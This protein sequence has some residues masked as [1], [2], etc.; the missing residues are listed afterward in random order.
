M[1]ILLR[2][3]DTIKWLP[4]GDGAGDGLTPI[5]LLVKDIHYGTPIAGKIEVIVDGHPP[6]RISSRSHINI[7]IPQKN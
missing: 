5:D 6:I 7:V 3:G 4:S 1:A 2:K